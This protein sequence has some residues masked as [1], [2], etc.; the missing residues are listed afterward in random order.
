MRMLDLVAVGALTA[1]SMFSSAAWADFA[2]GAYI[3]G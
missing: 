2:N 1:M 3:M